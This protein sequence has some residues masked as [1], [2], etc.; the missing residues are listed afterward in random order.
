MQ[1]ALFAGFL[2]AFL[3]ELLSRLEPDP[4]DTIQD[5]LIYQ[6]QMMRNASLGPY[7]PAEL[8][9]PD[10]YIVIVNT[11]F[12]ASL[13]IMLLAAFIAM[14][15][16]SWVREFD[17]GLQGMTIPEQRA[18]TREFRYLGMEYWKLHEVVALLPLLIQ[19]SLLLFAIGLVIFL[20]HI[21]KPSFHVTTT[22]FG[23][24]VIYYAV[25]TTISVFVTSS[26]FHSPLSRIFGGLWRLVHA[27]ICPG[28]DHFLSPNMDD[29]PETTLGRFRRWFKIS[30]QKLRPYSEK[31]FET[32]ITATTVDECQLNTAAS[33]LQRIHDSVPNSPHSQLIHQSVWQVAGSSALRIHP[34]FKLPTCVLDRGNDEEY[35]SRL[36]PA[37]MV[38]LI[39]VFVRMRDVRYKGRISAVENTRSNPSYSQE[40][41]AQLV[42]AIFDLLPNNLFTDERHAL[43]HP[44]SINK[45]VRRDAL[46]R[47][48]LPDV[49]LLRTLRNILLR[50]AL[51]N[52][53]LR[54]NALHDTL[55]P[56]APIRDTILDSFR[57][58]KVFLSDM[59]YGIGPIRPGRRPALD[60]P[61]TL[62]NPVAPYNPIA[63]RIPGFILFIINVTISIFCGLLLILGSTRTVA[64]SV[65]PSVLL[66]ISVS[67]LIGINVLRAPLAV[68]RGILLCDVDDDN[69]FRVV[70]V[71]AFIDASNHA[72][73]YA[74][75][76]TILTFLLFEPLILVYA[77]FCEA[78]KDPSAFFPDLSDVRFPD[79]RDALFPDLRDT[80]FPD[81]RDA[82]YIRDALFRDLRGA[83][84]RDLRDTLFRDA[85]FRSSFRL[86]RL[87]NPRLDA[88]TTQGRIARA[89]LK[90][91]QPKDLIKIL[92]KDRLQDEE[93]IWLLNTLS[94]LHCDGLVLLRVS[95][96]CLAILL[97]QAPK[98]NQKTSPN[99]M[100]IEA[101]VTLAAISCSSD[102]T[103]QRETLTNS[104]QHPWLLVNLRNPQLISTMIENVN[105]SS[106]KNL[107]SLLFLILYDLFLRGSKDLAVR[108]LA[109]ITAKCHFALCASALT[110]IAPTLGDSAFF[111][112]GASL[113]APQTHFLTPDV[114]DSTSDSS[115]IGLSHSLFDNYDL[116]LGTSQ[117][118]NPASL[119]ILLLL[120]KKLD[121]RVEQQ[122]QDTD[123]N[124]R[125][126]WL[127]LVA[128]VIARL[129]IP[130]ESG[131]DFEL[132]HDPRV[133]NMIAALSL[134]RYSEG[135]VV[136]STARESLL[137]ASFLPSRELVISSLTLHH[138]L[139]TVMTYSNPPPPSRHLSSA[140][141]ALFSPI[142]PD[143]YF[144]KGWKI[145]HMFMDEFG[146]L[147]I[148]WR[149]SFA[150]AFF[151]L[152]HQPLRSENRQNGAPVIELNRI[153]TWEYFCKEVRDPE[154]T[155][156]VFSGLDWMAMAWSLHLSQQSSTTPTVLAQRAA[157]PPSLREPPEDEEFVLQVLCRLLDA[158][159]YYSILPIIPKL[160]EL[161]EWLD[162]PRLVDYKSMV[163]AKMEGAE[164]E[165]ERSYKFQK[166]NCMWNL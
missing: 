22:I 161:V 49:P 84:F 91:E 131:M 42:H 48:A 53:P 157:Q 14:L 112:I 28:R 111:A 163:F 140:V 67:F 7:V 146:K 40:P 130:D 77:L 36:S 156:R 12:Y 62:D 60:N 116:L 73:L 125:N 103:Y 141:H 114:D 139:E 95:K 124:L 85:P 102:E 9:P 18:K 3:I 166:V 69:A 6:T 68:L 144:P 57:R 44:T 51:H 37:G 113:L 134:L 47:S 17:R 71:F 33:V 46:L 104:H 79:L 35:F 65:T 31:E 24:G 153:L 132:F 21:S 94:A 109:I 43:L 81:L 29:P 162:D 27:F 93:A 121:P 122:L 108:Y 23:I 154:F 45:A 41:M 58:A 118:P 99:I 76:F 74:P 150:E 38:G 1:A 19:I 117:L 107:I 110:V 16:K 39:S 97:H 30:L 155:D 50:N 4:L 159:P 11:L 83:L 127:Q 78:L 105:D 64:I 72:R 63:S 80:R 98:W 86:F 54:D 133:Y 34:L 147:P 165:C 59:I 100:L 137:L 138:Y 115:Q 20:F 32:S 66:G 135:K 164:Q 8:S 101:V 119:A 52:A 15:I 129:D 143:D 152:S 151:T 87:R 160:R 123:L 148:E 26:P 89:H 55:L 106:R 90:R 128:N 158:A 56:D 82:L 10:Q 5:I 13:G 149:Q 70:F 136:H 145:L 96:I 25:T 120:S 2:S 142:L 126:P 92:Q 75:L 88:M 61:I